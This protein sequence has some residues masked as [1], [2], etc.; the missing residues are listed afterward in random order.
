MALVELPDP[1]SPPSRLDRLARGEDCTRHPVLGC[2][3]SHGNGSSEEQARS[4][5][6]S[7]WGAARVSFVTGETESERE[8]RLA[9]IQAELQEWWRRLEEWE[10][11]MS[12]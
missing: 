1:R 2:I 10:K 8:W 9:K 6:Q 11:R 5:L 7:L 3:I 4:F 12:W